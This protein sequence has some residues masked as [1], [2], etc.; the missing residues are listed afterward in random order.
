M[1]VSCLSLIS[2]RMRKSASRMSTQ[3]RKGNRLKTKLTFHRTAEPSKRTRSPGKII[4]NSSLNFILLTNFLVTL[5]WWQLAS[6]NEMISSASDGSNQTIDNRSSM[7]INAMMSSSVS[8]LDVRC[9][10]CSL[11]IRREHPILVQSSKSTVR[12]AQ[13][14]SSNIDIGSKKAIQMT[15]ERISNEIGFSVQRSSDRNQMIHQ[16]QMIQQF[17][18]LFCAFAYVCSVPS[19]MMDKVE[20]EYIHLRLRRP[21]PHIFSAEEWCSSKIQN[22]IAYAVHLARSS[23]RIKTIRINEMKHRVLIPIFSM[24]FLF[25]NSH[26]LH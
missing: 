19:T 1:T 5:S 6:P 11:T 18:T 22:R 7:P 10:S 25:P 12:N 17:L 15:D 26:S 2:R 14:S 23:T 16:N 4:C 24:V 8:C 13:C 9:V 21:Y 20:R 3:E